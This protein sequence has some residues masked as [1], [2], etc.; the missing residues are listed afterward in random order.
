MAILRVRSCRVLHKKLLSWIHWHC[1]VSS[2]GSLLNNPLCN[3]SSLYW[4]QSLLC[5][6]IIWPLPFSNHRL[7]FGAITG[8]LAVLLSSLSTGVA[9]QSLPHPLSRTFAICWGGR[10]SSYKYTSTSCIHIFFA[11]EFPYYSVCTIIR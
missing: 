1:I 8:S 9:T 4:L 11:F 10:G 2:E 7:I 6:L 5:S 3:W